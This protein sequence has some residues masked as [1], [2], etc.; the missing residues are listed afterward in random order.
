MAFLSVFDGAGHVELFGSGFDKAKAAVD[1]EQFGP[2]T[3]DS[4]V[5]RFAAFCSEVN[6][7]S[8][9]HLFA[10]TGALVSGI[11]RKLAKIAAFAIGLG[12]NTGEDLAG[13]VFGEKDFAF[14]HH[15]GEALVVS[16]CAFE[17]GFDCKGG[18]M[19][20]MRR[21]RSA[22]MARR[23]GRSYIPSVSF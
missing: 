8:S 12:V 17:E 21:G 14:L 2:E 18:V 13:G 4:D 16:A 3:E 15:G 23:M 22:G 6:F 10:E 19:R 1:G 11:D 9:E 20:R 7:G 5:D